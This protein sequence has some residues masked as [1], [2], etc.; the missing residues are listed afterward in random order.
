MTF[1][2]L[3][4]VVSSDEQSLHHWA[5]G[6][7]S[8]K[9]QNNDIVVF[10]KSLISLSQYS[11]IEVWNSSDEAVARARYIIAGSKWVKYVVA[12]LQRVA[13]DA[14]NSGSNKLRFRHS[15]LD[16]SIN[17]IDIPAETVHV[18]TPALLLNFSCLVKQENYD[19]RYLI[20][21]SFSPT[22]T[23]ELAVL[24]KH[25]RKR[26]LEGLHDHN[27]TYALG[28][29]ISLSANYATLSVSC[30]LAK[31]DA[32]FSQHVKLGLTDLRASRTELLL[33]A[34]RN[35]DRENWQNRAGSV[36][37]FNKYWTDI[38]DNLSKFVHESEVVA[39]WQR[40]MLPDVGS[41][42][43]RTWGI[44]VET[45]QA[46]LVSRPGGWTA[47]TDGSLEDL[48]GNNSNGC[49]CDCDDCCDDDHCEYN[50]CNTDNNNCMEFVSPVLSHF[51]SNGLRD[52]CG[53]LE[54]AS[55]ND[56]P[57]IHVHVGAGDLTVSDV[58]R[59]V[60]AYS[61]VSPFLEPISYRNKRNYCRDISPENVAHWSSSIRKIQRQQMTSSR[62]N[63]HV[64]TI[65]DLVDVMYQQPDDRYRDLNLQSLN[66]HGTIEFRVMGP[67]YNY[68]H[69]VRWAWFCR[70]MVNVSRIDLPA[71]VWSSVRSMADVV[72]VLRQY[73]SEVPS[74]KPDG[75]L[76]AI[77]NVLNSFDSVI[78][79]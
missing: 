64:L 71:K 78:E 65:T 7:L 31:T 46:G 14:V 59:L 1:S 9:R 26:V 62:D 30:M 25:A 56:S 79:A 17:A 21:D 6:V 5:S 67:R 38:K 29:N 40:V 36:D 52:L 2:E 55:V 20:T 19:T 54:N 48:P 68:E 49:E 58:A 33:E 57:G 44:E 12:N 66:G 76:S 60:R 24:Y 70:E 45:V 3:D 22:F 28:S 4:V 69:L 73:G 51:H 8:D 10:G 34:T 32:R 47:V 23:G 37:N 42:S 75:E 15:G 16:V 41:N 43:S 39:S 11:N 13:I 74:D 77:K 50:D 27:N 35:A 53:P 63:N 61:I 18:K 72:S